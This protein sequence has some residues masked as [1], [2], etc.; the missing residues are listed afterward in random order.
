MNDKAEQLVLVYVTFN[1][2][3]VDVLFVL[4]PEGGF[5]PL[6]LMQPW[7]KLHHFYSTW[8]LFFFG[9]TFFINHLATKVKLEMVKTIKADDVSKLNKFFGTKLAPALEIY[10]KDLKESSKYMIVF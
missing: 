5:F 9:L 4:Q 2:A 1:D 6:V 10:N 7:G 3:I 8:Y